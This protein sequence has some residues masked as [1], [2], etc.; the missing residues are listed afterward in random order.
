MH[1]EPKKETEPREAN[2]VTFEGEGCESNTEKGVA[3]SEDDNANKD[4]STLLINAT[5]TGSIDHV[6][7][8]KLLSEHKKQAEVKKLPSKGK[9]DVTKILLKCDCGNIIK[10]NQNGRTPILIHI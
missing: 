6:D 2:K 8:R 7:I 10:I 1:G 5:K 9:I 3:L 4:I